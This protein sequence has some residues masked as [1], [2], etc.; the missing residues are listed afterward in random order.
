VGLVSVKDQKACLSLSRPGLAANSPLRLVKTAAPQS[1]SE[2][3]S[4]GSDASCPQN[5]GAEASAVSYA[6]QGDP[7]WLGQAGFAIGVVGFKGTFQQ[8]GGQ[9]TADLDGDG[10]AEYFRS[11]ASAEGLHL[12]VWS[13]K[14]LEGKLRWHGYLYLGYDVTPDCTPKDYGPPQ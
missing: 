1:V 13:G 8:E 5:A 4:G 11:C 9:V 6:V 2:G 3:R 10:V 12:T 7:A 14:P